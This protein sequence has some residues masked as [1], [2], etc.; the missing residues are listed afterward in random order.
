MKTLFFRNKALII[1]IL[2]ILCAAFMAF[3]VASVRALPV[4]A[5]ETAAVT[6]VQ[7]RSWG[8]GNGYDFIVLQNSAYS[9]ITADTT[10]SGAENYN[11]RSKVKIYTSEADTTGKYLT[12]IC[13]TWWTQ[14]LW[15]SGGL[16]LAVN[17]YNT[18]N[19]TTVYKIT[20]EAGCQLPCGD[21]VYETAETVSYINSDFGNA[22]S[23][24][25]AYNWTKE[26]VVT[27][28]EISLTGVQ[29]RG[30]IDGWYYYLVLKSDSYSG[31]TSTEGIDGATN[32][33][34]YGYDKIRLYTSADDT[35]G[36]V[37]SDLTL[38]HIGCNQWGENGL[39]INFAEYDATYNGTTVY[40]ITIEA[41]CKL[42]SGDGNVF[43]VDKDYSYI[44]GDYGNADKKLS[45]MTNWTKEIPVNEQTISLSGVQMRGAIDGWYYYLVLQSAAYKGMAATDGNFATT[46]TTFDK[47]RLYTSADDTT[48][49]ALSELTIQHVERNFG[50]W[51][52]GLFVNFAEYDSTYGGHQ[53]YKIVIEKGCKLL[54]DAGT[55][56]ITVF[57]TDKEYTYINNDYN[58][59]DKKLEATNWTEFTTERQTIALDGVQMRG[60]S[61]NGW[62]QFLVIRSSAFNGLAQSETVVGAIDGTTLDKIRI[63]T[64]AEDTTGIALSGLTVQHIGIN[65]GGWTDGLFINYTEY[66]ST[67]GG[68]A[69]YKVVVEEG[70]EL[71]AASEA[72]KNNVFVVDRDYTY[73]NDD[74]G[75]TANKYGALSW[76]GSR[77]TATFV[78]DDVT[79]GTAEFFYGDT[80]F[81]T[82]VPAVPAKDGYT[83]KWQTCEFPGND[84]IISAEYLVGY[85]Y[86]RS[87]S[88][89]GE[90]SVNFYLRLTDT[91]AS[92]IMNPAEGES[93]TAAYAD[94]AAQTIGGVEYR[95]FSYS[96]AAKRYDVEVALTVLPSDANKT[97]I[98]VSSS[99]KEYAEETI[100]DG[101]TASNL[102]DLAQSLLNYCSAAKAYFG[103]ETVEAYTGEVALDSYKPASSGTAPSGVT[104][105]GATLVLE[106]KT[107]IKIY[108]SGENASSAVCT[109]NGESAEQTR[110]D[111][112]YVIT[113]EN[114]VA[115]KLDEA[116]T[117]TIGDLTINYS[118]LS[119]A[120]AVAGN[121]GETDVNLINLV[122]YLYDYY[123]KAKD[124][125]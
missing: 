83:G 61:D 34:L 50:S 36:V 43:V 80:K 7:V 65:F 60:W 109:V 35:T 97:G 6:G 121:S 11:T 119:Y 59:A 56:S 102:K 26:T 1:T 125:F 41:G 87:I 100:K 24:N 14:N 45:A 37:L 29:M 74:Y 84:V 8:I 123:V 89:E 104:L 23:K 58:N 44:N 114:V 68:D 25:G 15:D 9:A 79:I 28:T 22:D 118:A 71:F 57:V 111:D 72:T 54:A 96:L 31:K 53:V 120:Y 38:Q 105:N 124:F 91:G 18:Y 81:A 62:Y 27:E 19:G 76:K 20:V 46:N 82:S 73:I 85:A 63:Y 30:A 47:I 88:L 116:Y 39:F 115:Q 90:I 40:K 99:V 17:D 5:A 113:I 12:E 3:A 95:V 55:D 51:T 49:K 66:A 86:G 52:D 10:V 107:A 64:S 108:F 94:S 75:N 92:V 21:T 32:K 4:S 13:G 106:S 33:T 98:T 70:C 67:Y 78:A 112:Y 2:S 101:A 110:E 93:V 122:K 117:I 103:N 69:V 48:G 42:P 16:M 77:Y